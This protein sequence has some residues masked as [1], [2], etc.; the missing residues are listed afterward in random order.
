MDAH[1]NNPANKY[2]FFDVSN[3]KK[4][5]QKVNIPKLP[6]PPAKIALKIAQTPTTPWELHGLIEAREADKGDDVKA[7]MVPIKNYCIHATTKG[8]TSDRSAGAYNLPLLHMPSWDLRT[9][10]AARLNATLGEREEAEIETPQDD[11][12]RAE[13]DALRMQM[14]MST[15]ARASA[16][17]ELTGGAMT[18]EEMFLRGTEAVLRHRE[19]NSDSMFKRFDAHQKAKFA[20]SAV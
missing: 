3:E 16:T 15:S 11:A 5:T 19:D 8:V 13:V 7:L 2:S 6:T 20:G 14:E 9:A 12:L 10:M 1:Y 17:T 4:S 18:E